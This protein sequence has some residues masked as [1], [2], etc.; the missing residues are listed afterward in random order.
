MI[1]LLRPLTRAVTYT[2]WLHMLLGGLP[3]LVAM[4]VIGS[5]DPEPASWVLMPVVVVLPLMAVAALVPQ[6]RVLEAAQARGLLFPGPHA[7]E[8]GEDPGISAGPSASWGDRGRVLCWLVLRVVSGVAVGIATF[9]L[10][11]QSMGLA[12][13][14]AGG[15]TDLVWPGVWLSWY[16]LLA[17]VPSVLLLLLVILAGR[18]EAAAARRLLGPSA[19]ERMAAL[20]ERTERLLEHNRL[21]RELHDSIGHALTVAVVQA[22]AAR[23]A[24]KPEFTERALTAIEDTGRQALEELDRVLRVLREDAGRDPASRPGLTRLTGLVE[25]AR[26][27]GAEVSCTVTGELAG[28]PGPVSREAYRIVQEALTNVLR[29]AGTVPVRL[30]VD[31]AADALELDVAN[32]LPDGAPALPGGGSGLRGIRERAA[33]LGGRAHTGGEDGAWRVRVRL[34]LV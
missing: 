30:R 13:G 33:L 3:S 25:A 32:P 20:E 4:M 23:A 2:R 14:P 5:P 18:L 15:A 29:H 28:V 9:W 31:A 12:F 10:T 34:P 27:S 17:P 8:R 7:R 1:T 22:G 11:G 21:A 16:A 6:T 24:G 19:A 26:A